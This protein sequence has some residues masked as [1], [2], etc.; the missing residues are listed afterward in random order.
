[1]QPFNDIRSRIPAQ[2]LA[3]LLDFVRV[4]AWFRLGGPRNRKLTMVAREMATR[5][6]GALHFDYIR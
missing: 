3:R 4:S 6:E 5:F 1:L 2:N